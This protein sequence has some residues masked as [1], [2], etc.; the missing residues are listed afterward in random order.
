MDHLVALSQMIVH[1]LAL[2]G[3]HHSG[4][5]YHPVRDQYLLQPPPLLPLPVVSVL[6]SIEHSLELILQLTLRRLLLGE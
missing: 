4:V 3:L 5:T 1:S 6:Q 2:T